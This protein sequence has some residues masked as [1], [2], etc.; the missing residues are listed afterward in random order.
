MKRKPTIKVTELDNKQ[1][2]LWY[3]SNLMLIKLS[4]QTPFK[5]NMS[6]ALL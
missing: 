6:L 1:P 3:Y 4:N 5:I 2:Q